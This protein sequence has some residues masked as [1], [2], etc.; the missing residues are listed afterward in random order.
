MPIS[1]HWADHN[2]RFA[3]FNFAYPVISRRA[4]GLS[5]G[6]NCTPNGVCSFNCVYCQVCKNSEKEKIKFPSTDEILL[7]LKKLLSIYRETK[8]AEHFPG[9]EEKDRMLKDIALS[10]DGEPTFYPY[11]AELCEALQKIQNECPE[12]PKLTLITNATQICEERII[13]GLEFLT[14]QNGEIWGKLDAGTDEFLQFIDRP[15]KKINIASIENNLKFAVSKFPLRIQTMLCEEQGQIPSKAEIESY[16]QI[17]RRI[18]EANPQNLLSIQL[19][20]V[21]RQT[22][23]NSVKSLPREFLENVKSILQNEI[24]KLCVE[25]F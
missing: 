22:A 19:Y 7:E 10:G 11:F 8:L 14:S 25:V 1:K 15:Q 16:T 2:R 4:K 12:N 5:V 9:I 13:S 20:S 6:I 3:G 23:D 21:V 17:V 24:S 18:Y